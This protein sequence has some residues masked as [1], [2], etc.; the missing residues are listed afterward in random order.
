M[1]NWGIYIDEIIAENGLRFYY[2]AMGTHDREHQKRE[3]LL[4]VTN[5]EIR[6]RVKAINPKEPTLIGFIGVLINNKDKVMSFS[7][8]YPTGKKEFVLGDIPR[9]THLLKR[10]PKPHASLE[11]RK[12]LRGIGLAS[13]AE[14]VIQKHLL[15]NF[16]GYDVK[17]KTRLPLGR[18]KQL[19]SRGRTS[20][21]RRSLEEEAEATRKQVIDQHRRK[22]L[23][24]KVA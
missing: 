17:S 16:K 15:K 24:R 13:L 1:E 11:Q 7:P 20:R 12:M 23:K 21:K 19:I 14:L 2:L 6:E 4:F 10:K 18:I 22:R 8:Y 3:K 9:F 5:P